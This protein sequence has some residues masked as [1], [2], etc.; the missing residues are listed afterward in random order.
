MTFPLV[1][2][3]TAA[4]L[5]ILQTVLMLTV[6]LHRF[7]TGVGVGFGD[8]ADL[9]RKIR[10]H[11]NLAEN[12]A[13][14]LAVLVVTELVGTPT[15]VVAGFGAAFIVARLSHALAFTSLA[16]SH[17]HEGSKVFFLL[18]GVGG[19]GTLAVGFG[20]GVLLLWQLSGVVA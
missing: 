3:Y 18:R 1:A 13:L 16:G 8:D 6:G 4:A 9:E 15:A 10:R 14:F 20:L 2:A 17:G 11:G 5:I 12:S 19:F 7:Q